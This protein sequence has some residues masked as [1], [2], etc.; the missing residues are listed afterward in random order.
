VT[1][2]LAY[3]FRHGVAEPAH[4]FNH[5]GVVNPDNHRSGFV[6]RRWA[7]REDVLERFGQER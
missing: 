2:R 3:K 5:K 1:R 7:I 4:H 6:H